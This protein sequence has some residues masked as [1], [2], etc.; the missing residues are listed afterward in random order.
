M[1]IL[2]VLVILSSPGDS[3]ALE[4]QGNLIPG[5]DGDSPVGR[6]AANPESIEFEILEISEED[7]TEKDLELIGGA[8]GSGRHRYSVSSRAGANTPLDAPLRYAPK[9]GPPRRS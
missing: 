6:E 9:Q 4:F 5:L 2:T 3:A 8:A 1:L 7:E